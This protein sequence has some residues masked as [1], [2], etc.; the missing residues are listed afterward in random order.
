MLCCMDGDA[1]HDLSPGDGAS[2]L[3][4]RRLRADDEQ[5]L[6]RLLE[7]ARCGTYV[8]DRFRHQARL[9][10]DRSGPWIDRSMGIENPAG[11][12]LAVGLH[13]LSEDVMDRTELAFACEPSVAGSALGPVFLE[14]LEREAVAL[15]RRRRRHAGWADGALR[16]RATVV[17]DPPGEAL[18]QARGFGF[19]H[20]EFDMT[21]PA[22]EPGQADEVPGALHA[23]DAHAAPW[24]FQAYEAAFRDRPGFP[25]WSEA[26]WRAFFTEY[27]AFRPDLSRVVVHDGRPV[28]FMVAAVDR[29]RRETVCDVVQI[30]VAPGVRRRGVAR[31]LLG[32]LARRV[33][34]AVDGFALSVNAN[35]PGARRLFAS[36]GFETVRRR[37]VYA[38]DYVD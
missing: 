4:T 35:N 9:H 2:R 24:F 11:G 7:R 23:F 27:D 36:L 14:A 6:A 15:C 38:K 20:A 34:D 16:L 13:Y 25:G 37:A 18:A 17:D 22:L 10:A 1:F 30:G 32:D 19:Q 3:T 26:R 8:L 5:E 28:A 12:L 29:R 31:A 33:G 21:C